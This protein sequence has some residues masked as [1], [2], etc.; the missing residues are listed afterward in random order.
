MITERSIRRDMA[1]EE[2]SDAEIE[3]HV[4]NFWES[5][6]DEHIANEED[7]LQEIWP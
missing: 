5:K 3:E 4:D 2:Y 7:K 1:E 6:I